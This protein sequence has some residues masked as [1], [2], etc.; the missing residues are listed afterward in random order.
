MVHRVAASTA[1]WAS[2]A[3]ASESDT[4]SIAP[5]PT[6]TTTATPL[7]L[8]EALPVTTSPDLTR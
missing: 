3:L 6:H 2:R 5:V 4:L 8:V 1:N 7:P